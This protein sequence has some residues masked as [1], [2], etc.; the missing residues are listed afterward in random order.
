MLTKPKTFAFTMPPAAAAGL[1]SRVELPLGEIRFLLSPPPRRRREPAAPC[2]LEREDGS[3]LPVK[4]SFAELWSALQA[5]GW[6]PPPY[7]QAYRKAETPADPWRRPPVDKKEA[8]QYLLHEHAL[9]LAFEHHIHNPRQPR[10]EWPAA[11]YTLTAFLNSNDILYWGCA[12]VDRIGSEA[13]LD[14]LYTFCIQ[15]PFEGTLR[16]CCWKNNMQPQLP[17]REKLQAEGQWDA[18]LAGLPPNPTDEDFA[19]DAVDEDDQEFL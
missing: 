8:L 15:D 18:F 9:F 17:W 16:Y 11:D 3:R 10:E 7:S 5:A 14:R 13:E 4:G 1:D 12:W 2:L 6:R 19:D